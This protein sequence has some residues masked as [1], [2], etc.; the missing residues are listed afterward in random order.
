MSKKILM[1]ITV[2]A[3]LSSCKRINP[4]HEYHVSGV[5][6]DNCQN[7]D[8]IGGVTLQVDMNDETF[9]TTTT[10][11][12][13]EFSMSGT[14]IERGG[15]G[16]G[17]AYL[18]IN[19]TPQNGGAFSYRRL[20]FLPDNGASL[21]TLYYEGTDLIELNV[22]ADTNAF[23]SSDTLYIRYSV[24]TFIQMDTHLNSFGDPYVKKYPG[25]F[26]QSI[27]DTVLMNGHSHEKYH[28]DRD[29]HVTFWINSYREWKDENRSHRAIYSSNG[30][31]DPPYLSCDNIR[32]VTLKL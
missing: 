24:P 27:L 22:L 28:S 30:V 17:V 21:D 29:Y 6:I 1:V 10:N 16:N 14:M 11:A 23:T 15:R 9:G 4:E 26:D 25:P 3:I 2:L 31:Q 8:P 19:H 12:F 32:S 20:A 7:G 13:G 18:A 5:L